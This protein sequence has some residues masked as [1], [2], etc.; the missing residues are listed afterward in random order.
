MGEL[1]TQIN[2]YVAV[3]YNDIE[4]FKKLINGAPKVVK[5]HPYISVKDKSGN[6]VKYKYI[7]IEQVLNTLDIVFSGMVSIE[8]LDTKTAFNAMIVTI[9]L[10]YFHPV[11]KVWM[12]Q[13]GVG[14]ASLQVDKN[15]SPTDM[16]AI[17]QE[18]VTMAL[19][20]AKTEAI[21]NAAKELGNKFGRGLNKG[22]DAEFIGS[23]Q[24]KNLL[25]F[26][27]HN[28]VIEKDRVIEAIEKATCVEDI[29]FIP[30]E[31]VNRHKLTDYY[32]LKKSQL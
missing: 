16:T 1:S 18:A 10:R 20:K 29:E 6:T 11:F 8:V 4:T 25:G 13:D 21:K 9:R 32:N 26:D 28:E 24:I 2:D 31:I 17:K 23:T 5:E 22:T 12:H 19:P 27:E 30:I 3:K 7:P 14:A 15:A